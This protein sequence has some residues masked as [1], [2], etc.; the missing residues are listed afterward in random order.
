ME[1]LMYQLVQHRYWNC[2]F[3][4]WLY[5]PKSHWRKLMQK[6]KEKKRRVAPEVNFHCGVEVNCGL[7][8]VP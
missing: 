8:L 3:R 7:A 5:G 2:H 4:E 6:E 1:L